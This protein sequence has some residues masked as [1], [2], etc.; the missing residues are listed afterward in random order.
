MSAMPGGAVVLTTFGLRQG[1]GT[2]YDL[3]PI[4]RGRR[5]HIEPPF[6]VPYPNLGLGTYILRGQVR[7]RSINYLMLA[8]V[9]AEMVTRCPAAVR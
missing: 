6:Y 4:W 9:G 5:Q 7:S 3:G 1:T 2:R 8:G